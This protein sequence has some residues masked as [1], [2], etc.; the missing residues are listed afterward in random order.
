MTNTTVYEVVADN[1]AFFLLRYCTKYA[2]Y[3][4]PLTFDRR[5]TRSTL[6]GHGQHVTRALR[7]G[8]VLNVT[9]ERMTT[10]WLK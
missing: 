8:D 10:V 7:A 2:C 6:G 4:T 1:T 9:V 3:G 5:K